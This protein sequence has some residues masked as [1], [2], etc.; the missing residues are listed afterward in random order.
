MVPMPRKLSR[1]VRW[2]PCCEIGSVIFL[3]AEDDVADTI[4]PR[5]DQAGADVSKIY[6]VAGTHKDDKDGWFSLEYDLHYLKQLLIQH[7]DTRLIIIDP[8][9]AYLGGVDSH[10]NSDVRGILAP[11][12]TLA[13]EHNVAIICINR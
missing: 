2:S 9:S 11:L 7:L 1:M 10:R 8:I 4:R 12:G 6:A 13:A 3:S 5:L